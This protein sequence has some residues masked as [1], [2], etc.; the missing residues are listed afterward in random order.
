MDNESFEA[1][2]IWQKEV[3]LRRARR[4]G[5]DGRSPKAKMEITKKGDGLDQTLKKS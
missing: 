2:N 1:N 5:Q 3:S 4:I